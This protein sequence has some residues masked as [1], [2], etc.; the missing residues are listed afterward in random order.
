M[1]IENC[2]EIQPFFSKQWK[3]LSPGV[4]FRLSIAIFQWVKVLQ[5][6]FPVFHSFFLLFGFFIFRSSKCRSMFA[7]TSGMR[8]F[9][10]FLLSVHGSAF[11]YPYN[12]NRQLVAIEWVLSELYFC[13]QDSIV[14][15]VGTPFAEHITFI[16][17]TNSNS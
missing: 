5:A 16:E 1:S 8:Y 17:S 4:I 9:F 14:D 2:Y 3:S 15:T 6:L 13:W 12:S 7:S 11:A 10:Y